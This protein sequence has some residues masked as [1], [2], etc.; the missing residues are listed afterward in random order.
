LGQA[1]APLPFGNHDRTSPVAAAQVF[2]GRRG[3]RR[4]RR[5]VHSFC[6]FLS[7]M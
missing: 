7:R 2:A 5:P 3:L 1:L 6:T 4:R